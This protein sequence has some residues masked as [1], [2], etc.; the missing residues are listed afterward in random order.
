MKELNKEH[1]DLVSGGCPICI[2]GAHVARVYGPRVVAGAVGI[3][4]GWFSE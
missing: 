3:A 1:I 4:A 2:I